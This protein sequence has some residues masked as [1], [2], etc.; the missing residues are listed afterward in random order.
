MIMK[1]VLYVDKREKKKGINDMNLEEPWFVVN[2][3]TR[4]YCL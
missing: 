1:E 2:V 4:N 3:I